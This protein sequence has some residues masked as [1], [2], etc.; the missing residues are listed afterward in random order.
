MQQPPRFVAK[1]ESQKVCKLQKSI[2]SLKQSPKAWFEKS[3][4]TLL[5]FGFI[6][7]VTDYLVFVKKT[8]KGCV[9]LIMHV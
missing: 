4:P 7:C 1:G 5:D 9:L 2:Y 6:R 3:S 8:S